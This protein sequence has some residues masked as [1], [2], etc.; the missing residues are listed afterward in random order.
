MGNAA[1]DVRHLEALDTIVGDVGHQI[2]I[3]DVE[4]AV[5]LALA[6]H[7]AEQFNLGIVEITAHLLDHPDVTEELRTQITIAHH[8]LANHAQMHVNQFD[9]FLL[10]GDTLG[11]HLVKLVG[12]TFQLA[13]Y[14]RVIDVFL[15]LKIRVQRA[16]TLARSLGNIVHRCIF[17]SVLCEQLA[18]HVNQLLSCLRY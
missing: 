2:D 14:H 7:L 13:F 17:K 8:R 10:R 6:E 9:D 5:I 1:V 11:C 12:K 18:S 3:V 4:L 15:R 16:A